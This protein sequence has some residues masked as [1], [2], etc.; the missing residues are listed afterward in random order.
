MVYILL[1]SNPIIF[2]VVIYILGFKT[3]ISFIFV[4]SI[5]CCLFFL[6]CVIGL[7]KQNKTN[8]KNYSIL[9][10]LLV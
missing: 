3:A 6:F 9:F 1:L 10:L 5:M 8:P 2:N 7:V 4:P